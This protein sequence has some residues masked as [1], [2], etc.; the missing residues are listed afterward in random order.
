M[1]RS[2]TVLSVLPEGGDSRKQVMMIF[3]LAVIGCGVFTTYASSL[4]FRY[5]SRETGI[6]LALGAS[7]KQIRTELRREVA[8]ISFGSCALGAALGT[9]LAWLIWRLFQLFIVDTSEMALS[10]D[11][12]AY[13]FALSF[14]AFVIVMLFWMLSRFVRRTN[15]IDIVSESRKS[16]PFRHVPRWYGPVG[17]LLLIA[18]ALLGYLTPSFC[19]LVLHWYPPEGLTAIMYLP[20]FFGI[21]MI[22]LHT[23]VHGFSKNRYKHIITSSMM[24]FQGRQTVRN[25]LII[26]VLIAGAY[27]ASF[28]TP[29]LGTSALMEIDARNVDYAFHYR[30]DQNMITQSE[31]SEMAKDFGVTITSFTSQP[32]VILGVDGMEHIEQKSRL[33]ETYTKEY[34]ELLC[35]DTFL[36]ESAYNALTGEHVDLLPGTVT[37]VF[38]DNGNS[39]GMVDNEVH[40]ITNAITGQTLSVTPV[41]P[42]LCNSMLFGRRVLD[43]GDYKKMS[44]GLTN[45]W[46]E[47]QVFFNVETVSKTYPFAKQL[48]HEIVSRSGPEVEVYDAW[49][50][51]AQMRADKNGKPYELSNENLEANGFE[52][53]EYEKK[54][55]SEFRLYWKYM[56]QF[57]VLDKADFVQTV[58]VFLMLF[59][60]ISILCFAAV[61]VI[62]YTRC[63]TIALMNARVYDDLRH[64]GA[65]NKYLYRVVKEQVSRVFFVPVLTGTSIIYAFYL[66][67]MYFNDNGN[68]SVNEL[69]GLGNCLLLVAAVSAVLYGIYR[70]TLR[71]VC[72]ELRL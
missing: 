56:P 26:T 18:G 36:S 33:G 32:A 63:M 35:S 17:I 43:D 41:E 5:K 21:Y 13:L 54:D 48:F 72:R 24:K 28:Y 4:F 68:L 30:A 50:P 34:R 25:M 47:T 69:V 66:M 10:F 31:I 22:L 57:R 8:L 38:D 46:Q 58:A 14:S 15:I 42:V 71:R 1:M 67:I 11:R 9:P 12:E 3:V 49:D 53:I 62:L 51:I 6:Y 65:S 16:E 44:Y 40:L 2:S 20:A 45:E 19:V 37:T 61:V 64:L 29:M 7:K 70:A 27:F 59:I 52:R 23:V 55:S 60:F 39:N